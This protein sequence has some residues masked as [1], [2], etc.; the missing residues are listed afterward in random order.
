MEKFIHLLSS[1]FTSLISCFYFSKTSSKYYFYNSNGGNNLF[2]LKFVFKVQP[3]SNFNLAICVFLKGYTI[4]F[5]S[6][7]FS[8]LFNLTFSDP[9]KSNTISIQLN[10]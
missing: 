6:K 4:V 9:S 5:I 2:I 7:D 8:L 3:L 10:I 1:N